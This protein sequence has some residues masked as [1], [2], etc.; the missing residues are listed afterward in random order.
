MN[1]HNSYYRQ[2]FFSL[3]N[4]KSI[5]LFS[6]NSGL[7]FAENFFLSDPLLHDKIPEKYK[8]HKEIYEDAIMKG[9][10]VLQKVQQL[11]DSGKGGMDVFS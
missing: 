4:R 10:R 11:H 6:S 8:S 7:L 5:K 2:N 9:C 1:L 3:V